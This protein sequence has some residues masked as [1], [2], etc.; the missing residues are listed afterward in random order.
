MRQ[1]SIQ[2][3]LAKRATGTLTDE[4]LA[5]LNTL[6]RRDEVVAGAL[7][8]AAAL[9]RRRRSI[10]AMAAAMVA[11]AAL[12]IT[13]LTPHHGDEAPLM[14]RQQTP[15]QPLVADELP[16][17]AVEAMP[18]QTAAIVADKKAVTTAAATTQR[19]QQPTSHKAG[20]PVVTCN[21]QCDADSVINDIWKFLTA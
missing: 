1:D 7:R 17:T 21:S 12:G 3:L 15:A 2:E 18:A 9:R 8:R 10:A 16:A 14:A 19:R 20:E 13:L 6:I 5:T 11:V 4:E